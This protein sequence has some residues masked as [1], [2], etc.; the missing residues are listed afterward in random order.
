MPYGNGL[1][2]LLGH[3]DAVQDADMEVDCQLVT[4]G[5]DPE[6][7]WAPIRAGGDPPTHIGALVEEAEGIRHLLLQLDSDGEKV[8]TRH[9]FVCRV[10]YMLYPT[11]EPQSDL[12][13]RRAPSEPPPPGGGAAFLL[14]APAVPDRTVLSLSDILGSSRYPGPRP[15]GAY[16]ATQPPPEPATCLT[17]TVVRF[18]KLISAISMIKAASAGSS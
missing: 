6:A 14:P 3:P 5:I 4:H 9:I 15:L 10:A 2:Q 8:A 17:A 11:P 16:R 12:S 1:R 13:A 18:Q 7:Y